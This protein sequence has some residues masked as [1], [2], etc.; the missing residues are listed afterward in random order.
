MLKRECSLSSHLSPSADKRESPRESA[1]ARVLGDSRF[2]WIHQAP[3]WCCSLLTGS[4]SEMNLDECELAL[5]DPV[6]ETER[7]R[8]KLQEQTRGFHR[9]KQK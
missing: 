7:E 8:E 2:S 1:S 3:T 5:P 4:R 9:D 6:R